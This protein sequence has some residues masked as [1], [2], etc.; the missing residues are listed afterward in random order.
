MS[1]LED[2]QSNLISYERK[3][4]LQPTQTIRVPVAIAENILDFAH[5]LDDSLS[6]AERA[7]EAWNQS[8]VSGDSRGVEDDIPY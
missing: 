5:Q 3:W 1:D 7:R 4:Y 6:Q 8:A 2:N